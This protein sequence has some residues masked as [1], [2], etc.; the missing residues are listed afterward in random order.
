MFHSNASYSG[1]HFIFFYFFTYILPFFFVTHNFRDMDKKVIHYY[2]S[3]LKCSC[4]P[5]KVSV[6]SVNLMAVYKQY[7]NHGRWAWGTNAPAAMVCLDSPC[8]QPPAADIQCPQISGFLVRSSFPSNTSATLRV[9][10]ATTGVGTSI[11]FWILSWSEGLL[12][13]N[14]IGLWPLVWYGGEFSDQ[15]HEY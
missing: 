15:L 3:V 6:W 10:A 9:A 4:A 8:V 12:Y 1:K 7:C 2:C 11:R 14:G 13:A 5:N